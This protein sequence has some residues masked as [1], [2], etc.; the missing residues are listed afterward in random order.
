MTTTFDLAGGITATLTERFT[1]WGTQEAGHAYDAD[2]RLI[3]DVPEMCYMG[4][5]QSCR[6]VLTLTRMFPMDSA[7]DFY[8]LTGACKCDA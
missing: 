2:A 6:H 5:C 3:A 1:P 4:Y 8:R 7:E